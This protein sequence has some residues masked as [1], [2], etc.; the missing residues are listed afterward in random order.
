MLSNKPC[1]I[2]FVVEDDEFIQDLMKRY[3]S[4]LDVEIFF[5]ADGIEA[6]K[7]YIR[8]LES[9]KRPDIVIMDINLPGKDGIEVTKDIL[10][11]DPDAVIY[12]FTAFYG[13]DKAEKLKDAGARKI[14]P[15]SVG[16]ATFRKIIED[17]L[18]EQV[19]MQ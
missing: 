5:A 11:I 19:V 2:I 7:K 10:F 17:A 6:V 9:N 13:T 16:F 15:R 3:L 12:G 8:L 1:G 18:A 4:S 14:S